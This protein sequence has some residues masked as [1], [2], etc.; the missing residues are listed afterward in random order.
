M[1]SLSR[2][3]AR[4]LRSHS[5]APGSEHAAANDLAAY[6]RSKRGDR[7]APSRK[8]I[9]P[10]E[11]PRLLLP[12]VFMF[13]VIGG[14]DDFRYRLIGTE[15]VDGAGRDAT[16]ALISQLYRD[17]PDSLAAVIQILR[18]VMVEKRPLFVSGRMAWLRR[19]EREK[20]F[21]AVFL[22]LSPDDAQSIDIVFGGLWTE[23][24]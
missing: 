19:G 14:G 6:W 3:G 23:D 18:R 1:E 13:D 8:D 20:R 7:I 11:I 12:H 21:Q 24:P 5:I 17:S 16:G 9:D 4:L 10:L 2:G 22:P 15:I